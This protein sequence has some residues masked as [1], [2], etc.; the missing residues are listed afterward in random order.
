MT[1]AR[2]RIRRRSGRNIKDAPSLE[3]GTRTSRASEAFAFHPLAGQLAR[4]ADRLRLLPRL[5]LGGLLVAAAELHFAEQA[6]A[7][8]LLLERLQGLVDI[9]VADDDL[10]DGSYSSGR[11]ATCGGV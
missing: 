11:A 1:G 6:L 5:A 2:Q 3:F 4:P 9:V 8:H 10:D 7:L